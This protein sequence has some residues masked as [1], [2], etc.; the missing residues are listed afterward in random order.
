MQKLKTHSSIALLVIAGFAAGNA[1]AIS[2]SRTERINKILAAGAAGQLD[3]FIDGQICPEI[4][5]RLGLTGAAVCTAE[6]NL[7]RICF[8]KTVDVDDLPITVANATMHKF[9]GAWTA[10][11]P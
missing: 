8:S 2:W 10:T 4:D 11:I 5:T 3:T 7:K 1:Y 6:K 9:A